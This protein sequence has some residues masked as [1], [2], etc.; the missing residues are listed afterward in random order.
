MGLVVG[1][2]AALGPS[3]GL[4][5]LSFM[6]TLA[7]NGFVDCII[8]IHTSSIEP[9]VERRVNQRD[10]SEATKRKIVKTR[11]GKL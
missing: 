5:D 9:V 1:A 11:T 6:G 7:T 10:Q 2:V 3:E 4:D 8:Y